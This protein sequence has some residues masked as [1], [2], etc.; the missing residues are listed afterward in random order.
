MKDSIKRYA[1]RVAIKATREASRAFPGLMPTVLTAQ[2][3]A[4][5]EKLFDSQWYHFM[6]VDNPYWEGDEQIPQ[7][8]RWEVWDRKAVAKI[9][10]CRAEHGDK[11]LIQWNGEFEY[12]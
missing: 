12:V 9:N 8:L 3:I 6:I 11:R 4:E 5:V 10:E 2:D 7:D 1:A